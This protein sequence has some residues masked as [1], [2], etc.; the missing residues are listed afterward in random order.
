MNAKRDDHPGSDD[1]DLKPHLPSIG[2]GARLR[3]Y[4]LTGVL[5]T[6]PLAITFGLAWWFVDFVD[7]KVMPL[8]PEHYNPVS[9]LPFEY[10]DY[11]IPG[12][13]VLVIVLVVI[14]V[15]WFTTNFAGRA[16][17]RLYEKILGRIPA[18]RSI[19]GAV[20]Q[21]LETVLANQSNAFRQAV[22]I[23]YPRRGLWCI[24]FITGQTKGEIQ[25]LTED[26]VVNIFLPTTPNPT[27][28]FLLFVPKSDMVILN[29][30]VEEAIKMVMSGGIVTPPDR[31]SQEL[32]DQ[33]VV[34]AKTYEDVDILRERENT[35]VLVSRPQD[36]KEDA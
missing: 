23:E 18:V 24:G 30:G 19:Y 10:R 14:F 8:I 17:I 7:G 13:G 20:K 6:A 4:F 9:Y 31:R 12:L 29:M 26:T 27:S 1:D 36:T 33:P 11:G 3:A 5:V 16:L 15:G 22:L 21:I 25:H 28:G 34:S 2:L 35:P 32:Q